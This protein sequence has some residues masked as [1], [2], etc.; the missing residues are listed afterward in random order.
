VTWHLA[1]LTAA[2]PPTGS[3]PARLWASVRDWL[4][5]GRSLPADAWA[6]CHR[7]VQWL[8]V[9]HIPAIMAFAEFEHHAA[10]GET[11]L[12]GAVP[13]IGA[14]V[15]GLPALSRS[16]RS[17]VSASAL[18]LC[19]ALIVHL[20]DGAIEAH[21]HFFVMIPVIAL[22]EDW[23][24]FGVAVG[25]VLVEH[26]LLGTL[27][28]MDVYNDAPAWRHPWLYAGIHAGFFATAAA[29][30]LLNWRLQDISREAM[31]A[32]AGGLSD[33]A[34]RDNLT[35][36]PNRDWLLDQ[37]PAELDT[38]AGGSR[39]AVLILDIDRFKDVNDTLGYQVGDQLLREVAERLRRSVGPEDQ[40][41]RLGGDEFAVVLVGDRAAQA[42]RVAH[43][44]HR[45]LTCDR[46][47][48]GGVDI[49]LEL[50][51]GLAVGEGLAAIPGVLDVTVL[52]PTASN[53]RATASPDASTELFPAVRSGPA[54]PAPPGAPAAPV[55][56]SLERL[57]RVLRQG[58]VAMYAAKARRVDVG[59]YDPATDRN[60][61]DR[62]GLLTDLREALYSD[63][64]ALAFQ[65]K[66]GLADG[67]VHGVEALLRWT[68]PSRGPVPP[69]DFIPAAE[70]TNLITP[71]SHRVL[72]M[73]LLQAKTW[74]DEGTPMRVS[75]N[76]PPRCLIEGDFVGVVGQALEASG[77][78]PTLLCLELTETSL[79]TDI[80]TALG[81]ISQ[82]S[83]LGIELS[84]DDF[85]TGFSSLSYLRRLPVGEL[86]IDKSFVQGVL[87]HEQDQI[88]IKATIDLAHRLG[89]SVVAEGVED[90]ESAAMLAR[91]GC[92]LAQGYL[93]SRPLAGGDL[94]RWIV[95]R[96]DRTQHVV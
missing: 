23:L 30:A 25:F 77:V 65:P 56:G 13:A 53:T 44:L 46:V 67:Q 8:L 18:M 28:P 43:R 94:T 47:S 48:L 34:W 49:D 32:L 31:V 55:V 2:P 78:P 89:M 11:L 35:G 37:L 87:V 74:I 4:P 82:L 14:T 57:R 20:A 69:M 58:D 22:Y 12:V 41:A 72:A 39:V 27:M 95:A 90:D 10:V 96:A 68:H 71:L 86:K 26:G 76:V 91:L 45:D 64:L 7:G 61:I 79:M 60:T 83:G 63:Q 59:V 51:V 88:L 50:T 9:L 84:I 62:L 75:V 24:P 66:I 40:V 17:C 1:A 15:A 21:F 93:Y 85:G 5:R 92:D 38:L 33:R 29:G 16:L 42:Y 52:S 81:V 6:A 3:P 70:A 19:S 80:D 36:L 54:D 73:A